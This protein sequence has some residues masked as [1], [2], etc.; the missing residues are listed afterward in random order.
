MF[1]RGLRV[2]R[3]LECVNRTCH[4]YVP[5]INPKLTSSLRFKKMEGL[6]GMIGAE[7]GSD[8]EF[9]DIPSHSTIN[10]NIICSETPVS[11]TMERTELPILLRILQEDGRPLPIGSFTERSVARKVH[12]LIGITLE[13]V[14]MVTPSDAILEFPTG[15]L[16]VHIAQVL[17]AMKEWED[18]PIYVSCLM[19]NRCYI[20][21]VCQYRANYEAKRELEM[22]AERL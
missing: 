1:V 4:H 9:H 7:W 20:M 17:H 3:L 18:F 13:R 16:V 11:G 15:C 2:K 19:G 8:P 21:E 5:R 6:Q 12:N 22:E 10:T 14:T